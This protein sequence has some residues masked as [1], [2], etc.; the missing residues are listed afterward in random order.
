MYQGMSSV[1]GQVERQ[2]AVTQPCLVE[3]S[4]VLPLGVSGEVL[5]RQVEQGHDGRADGVAD[6]APR[7]VVDGLGQ[8]ADARHRVFPGDLVGVARDELLDELDQD[9]HADAAGT[10][11]PAGFLLQQPE[12]R[13]AHLHRA[14][15]VGEKG[16]PPG[17]HALDG[18][19]VG[20][21][22]TS[23]HLLGRRAAVSIGE[24]QRAARSLSFPAVGAFPPVPP[25]RL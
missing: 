21:L 18:L 7:G 5:G 4:Q 16:A 10:A 2:G 23:Q 3:G 22:K 9:V 12:V 15:V 25:L 11:A 19:H 24:S 14:D 13:Q 8:P 6:A 1:D 17:H 20:L